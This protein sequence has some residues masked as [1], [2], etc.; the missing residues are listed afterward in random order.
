MKRHLLP[1]LLL[2][3]SVVSA[4]A[5]ADEGHSH[6]NAAAAPSANGP[7]R[8]P[9]GSVFLPKP[10][11]R[12]IALRTA[13]LADGLLPRTVEL[14]GTV[15][16][17]PN[18]GGRV[19]PLFAG[20]L[21]AGPK[22]LPVPGQ[23]VRKGEVL[24][25]VMP[26]VTGLERSTQAAQLA[27]LRASQALSRKRLARLNELADTVPR[28]EIE[29]AESELAGLGERIGALGAGLSARDTLVA[30]VA[31]VIA[32]VNAVLGQVVDARE[33]VFEIVD[34]TRM[35][36]EAL[37]FDGAL[38]ADIAGAFVAVGSDRIALR[39]IGASRSLRDQAVPLSFGAQGAGLRSLALG[40][41]VK[42]IVQ[43]RTQVKGSSV[44]SAALVK[45]ASN[46]DIV[47]VKT[48]PERFEPRVVTTDALD[49]TAVALTSG[50][51]GGERVVTQGAT[52]LNQ[53]R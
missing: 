29:A 3:L 22:G 10:A 7:Q 21:E 49:G 41:P 40:Q 48:A 26:A 1:L 38:A 50:V 34:P 13:M 45:N 4:P 8:L 37:A 2:A 52:L 24:A 5:R 25:Y 11:Q 20:R 35:R 9:D 15:V 32:S 44:A 43:T 16:M 46:Q 23:A 47:W 14:N 17:D 53:I 36:V 31:G 30:P 12:Q 6:D 42:V 39:F 27:D 18:A 28:R 51:R 19:Q 33:L